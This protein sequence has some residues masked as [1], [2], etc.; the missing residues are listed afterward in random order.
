MISLENRQQ[1]TETAVRILHGKASHLIHMVNRSLQGP[2]NA[3]KILQESR[4]RAMR[5]GDMSI[6]SRMDNQILPMVRSFSK[7]AIH[8]SRM[9]S[10]AVETKKHFSASRL[11]Q[12]GQWIASLIS[13]GVL[14]GWCSILENGPTAGQQKLSMWKRTDPPARFDRPNGILF[15]ENELEQGFG[16][17]D[18]SKSE[19]SN[20]EVDEFGICLDEYIVEVSVVREGDAWNF[21]SEASPHLTAQITASERL[22]LPDGST[23]NKV[24]LTNRLSK[25]REERLEITQDAGKVLEEVEKARMLMRSEKMNWWNE[26]RRT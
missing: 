7:K 14:P 8:H 5:K 9:I 17:K 21:H 4:E 25:G 6:V 2:A 18:P 1:E 24:V 10:Q 19:R 20:G 13:S 3:E 22:K 15:T 26:Y 11:K 12:R 16:D 23:I